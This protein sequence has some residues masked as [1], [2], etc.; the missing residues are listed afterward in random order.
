MQEVHRG[1]RRLSPS[2]RRAQLLE[3]GLELLD[4]EPHQPLSPRVVADR[5]A[6]VP[7]LLY[8][9]FPD[10][11][12]F[13]TEVLALV[14]ERLADSSTEGGAGD[15]LRSSLRGEVG[16]ARRHAGLWR[17]LHQRPEAAVARARWQARLEARL[18]RSPAGGPPAARASIQRRGWLGFR[19]A[20]IEAW[21]DEP[22]LS[23]EQL[24]DLLV[25]ATASGPR[26]R[27]RDRKPRVR[28]MGS[29]RGGQPS[30]ARPARRAAGL[31]T[32]EL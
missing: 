10:R 29:V 28:L 1:R 3:I 14:G 32:V 22:A 25:E 20:A 17:A 27:P 11:H 5:A 26:A 13:T 12:A 21:L 7:G 8:R 2:A 31:D 18:S 9:Y 19:Q 6:T 15:P 16:F 4:Q 23:E 30:A 24:I